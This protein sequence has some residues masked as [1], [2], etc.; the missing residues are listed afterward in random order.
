MLLGA[1][2]VQGFL[3]NRPLVRL[4]LAEVRLDLLQDGNIAEQ[5]AESACFFS[6]SVSSK[7]G[8]DVA[9]GPRLSSSQT[10]DTN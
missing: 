10:T 7:E 3:H 6:T 8:I 1:V 4:Q 5:K 2:V 9:S